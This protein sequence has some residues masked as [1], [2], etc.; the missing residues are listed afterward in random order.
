[1]AEGKILA[2]SNLHLFLQ[3]NLHLNQSWYGVLKVVCKVRHD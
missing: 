1:M 2:A 3:K